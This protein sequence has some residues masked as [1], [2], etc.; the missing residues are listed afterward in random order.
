MGGGGGRESVAGMTASVLKEDP[1]TSRFKSC[2]LERKYNLQ[3][4]GVIPFVKPQNDTD[5]TVKRSSHFFT[6]FHRLTVV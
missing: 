1:N 6:I 2:L 3:I 5:T 4:F